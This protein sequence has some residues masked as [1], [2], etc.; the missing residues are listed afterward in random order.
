M[1]EAA[2]REIVFDTETTGLDPLKGDRLVEIA[3]LEGHAAVHGDVLVVGGGV[4]RV[5]PPPVHRDHP[6][7]EKFEVVTSAGDA[8]RA[9]QAF[10]RARQQLGFPIDGAVVKRAISFHAAASMTP[11]AAEAFP[12]RVTKPGMMVW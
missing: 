4:L 5:R 12:A 8:W 1:R 10:G 3:A 7:V 11:K 9:I 6:G 2:L